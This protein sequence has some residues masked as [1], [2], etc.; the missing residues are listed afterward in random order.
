MSFSGIDAYYGIP[1]A[2]H[3]TQYITSGNETNCASNLTTVKNTDNKAIHRNSVGTCNATYPYDRD[4]TPLGGD[5]PGGSACST[6]SNQYTSSSLFTGDMLRADPYN[7]KPRG[8]TE[9]QYALLKARAQA[10]GLY[11]TTPNPGLSAWPVASNVPNP[12]IYFKL[13]ANQEV[14]INN[15]LNTYAWSDDPSC[16]NDHPGVVIIVEGGNLRLNS[17]AVLSGAVFVPDGFLTYNG[18]AQLVGT[19]FTEQLFMTGNSTITLNDCYTRGTPGG[20]LDI[21]PIRFRE[22]DR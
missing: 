10:L 22:V 14:Q 19:V 18:G 4:N 5:F 16:L 15:E 1:A 21:R 3:S 8:L 20:V 9:A 17:N 11:F 12:V 6:A 13:S 2:V 7:F